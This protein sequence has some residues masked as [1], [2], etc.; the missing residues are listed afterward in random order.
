MEKAVED[1]K[2]KR[3][4][5]VSIDDDE[6]NTE[7]LE[8]QPQYLYLE[9]K[10]TASF[11]DIDLDAMLEHTTFDDFMKGLFKGRVQ[12]QTQQTKNAPMTDNFEQMMAK[13]MMGEEDDKKPDIEL[14]F[15]EKSLA[16]QDVDMFSENM[17]AQALAA[18]RERRRR[19]Q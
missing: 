17:E 15:D 4:E 1:S 13:I 6:L 5:F 2:A 11:K 18:V 14:Q 12:N 7:D 16:K 10:S 8:N 3:E 19:Q 9:I